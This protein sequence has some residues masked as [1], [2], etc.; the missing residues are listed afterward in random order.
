MSG[1]VTDLSVRVKTEHEG[2]LGRE[3]LFDVLAV[4]LAVELKR[5]WGFES[6]CEGQLHLLKD[7]W[8]NK[9]VEIG[10]VGASVPVVCD[11]TTVHDLTVDVGQISVWYLFILGQVVVKHISADSK[12]TIVE[13]VES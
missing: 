2:L 10:V 3:L 5:V 12:I 6:W 4:R 11:V 9:N 13:V 7:F 1:K 8:T